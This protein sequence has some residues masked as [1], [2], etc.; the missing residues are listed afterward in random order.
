MWAACL[1]YLYLH[2]TWIICYIHNTRNLISHE[3]DI[4]FQRPL[5]RWIYFLLLFFFSSGVIKCWGDLKRSQHWGGKTAITAL[6]QWSRRPSSPSFGPVTVYI[7]SEIMC[8]V[9]AKVMRPLGSNQGWHSPTYSYSNST[10]STFTQCHTRVAGEQREQKQQCEEKR[11]KHRAEELCKHVGAA[12]LQWKIR[13]KKK[14]NALTKQLDS[15]GDATQPQLMRICSIR[16]TQ[17]YKSGSMSRSDRGAG[18]L[19]E[20]TKTC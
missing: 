15:L 3:C 11:D 18:N 14:N 1:L 9:G 5:L 7:K 16:I 6:M 8:C 2:E 19:S 12:A 4:E 10:A 17:M 13:L 20:I